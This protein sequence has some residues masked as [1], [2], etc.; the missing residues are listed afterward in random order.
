MGRAGRQKLLGK[1][2][3]VPVVRHLLSPLKDYF[4][5][6]T[7]RT[8]TPPVGVA[9]EQGEEG[10]QGADGTP[11]SASPTPQSEGNSP[12]EKVPPSE[13]TPESVPPAEAPPPAEGMP[14]A[15]RVC[16]KDEKQ[17]PPE[18]KE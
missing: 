11:P 4:K 10:D 14:C 17:G 5:S 7:N 8:A 15:K 18:H 1:S 13:E 12:A 16:T 6:N 3:S 2:W 9:M